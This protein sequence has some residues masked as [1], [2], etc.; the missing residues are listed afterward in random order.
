MT[1]TQS[2]YLKKHPETPEKC[3]PRHRPPLLLRH[4]KHKTTNIWC[5][6]HY[7]SFLELE[8]QLRRDF[9]INFLSECFPG[10]TPQATNLTVIAI[11]LFSRLNMQKHTRTRTHSH[12]LVTRCFGGSDIW[13]AIKLKTTC[14][15]VESYCKLQT[16]QCERLDGTTGIPIKC[17]TK[18]KFCTA[19]C[20]SQLIC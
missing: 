6:F 14:T 4:S 13:Q 3:E 19:S 16:L 2:D 10:K 11:Y 7:A 9:H 18:V 15:C 1:M 20:V 8:T 5:P 12:F 17:S